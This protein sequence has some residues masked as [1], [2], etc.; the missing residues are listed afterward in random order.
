MVLRLDTAIFFS[1]CK[2]TFPWDRKIVC[3]RRQSRKM[4]SRRKIINQKD[5]NSKEWMEREK[6]GE[7]AE[8]NGSSRRKCC[9]PVCYQKI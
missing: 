9:L 3:E 8:Q 5:K 6:H 4:G 7:K 1:E 2:K